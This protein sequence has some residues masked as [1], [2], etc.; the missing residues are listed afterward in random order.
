METTFIDT[1]GR[2][3]IE[4]EGSRFTLEGVMSFEEWAR[5]HCGGMEIFNKFKYNDKE[6][7][8]LRWKYGLSDAVNQELNKTDKYILYVTKDM[9]LD[10]ITRPG[11]KFHIKNK[12]WF[13]SYCYQVKEKI[14]LVNRLPVETPLSKLVKETSQRIGIYNY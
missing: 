8:F 6:T 9:D 1:L 4:T 11:L 14:G 13:E 3:H 10:K 5:R 12:R 2:E 7:L